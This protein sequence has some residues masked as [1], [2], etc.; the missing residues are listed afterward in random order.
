MLVACCRLSAAEIGQDLATSLTLVG[1]KFSTTATLA[2]DSECLELLPYCRTPTETGKVY[3]TAAELSADTPAGRNNPEKIIGYC[4]RALENPL[5]LWDK[6]RAT[7]IMGAALENKWLWSKSKHDVFAA[8][9][10]KGYCLT[11]TMEEGEEQLTKLPAQELWDIDEATW[12]NA[13]REIAE[14]YLAGIASAYSVVPPDITTTRTNVTSTLHIDSFSTAP[15]FLPQWEPARTFLLRKIP[16]GAEDTAKR[17]NLVEIRNF[18]MVRLTFLYGKEPAAL[19]E[20]KALADK[21]FRNSG[22]RDHLVA[23]IEKVSR[24]AN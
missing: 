7:Q 22:W 20:L 15:T 18:L 12:L 17:N 13:R 16:D 9:W 2:L 21:H 8:A 23:G 6:L 10:S 14:V 11:I 1:K 3:Y 4:Q 24:Q 19:P 5:D